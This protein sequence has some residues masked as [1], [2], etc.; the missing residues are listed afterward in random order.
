MISHSCTPDL[1]SHL[2]HS[3]HKNFNNDV[4]H[5]LQISSAMECLAEKR[6]VH[7]DLAARNV[8]LKSTQH[9]QVTDFGLAAMLQR[10]GDSVVV[11]GKVPVRWLAPE[12]LRRQLYNE[13]TDVWSFGVTCWEIL[14]FGHEK[15][16]ER[17]LHPQMD[18]RMAK[19]L[20]DLLENG[21]RL[22]QP[23]NC[24]LELY[25][26]LLECMHFKYL[27]FVFLIFAN[28]AFICFLL[29]QA[30]CRV[31]VR[32]LAFVKSKNGLRNSAVRRTNM[33]KSSVRRI[34]GC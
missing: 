7:R 29:C 30:G 1:M 34:N 3:F 14:T 19:Q 13:Q 4:V 26:T 5:L 16:Y 6:I 31:P 18:G 8:L 21:L 22:K 27:H 2:P 24:S 25:D 32:V 11:E 12:S 10:P 23:V 15:P 33:C 9:V 28:I 20:A 17:E